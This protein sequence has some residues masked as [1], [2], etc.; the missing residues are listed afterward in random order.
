MKPSKTNNAQNRLFDIRLSDQLNPQNPLY[1]LSEEIDWGYFENEFNPLFKGKNGHPPKPIRLMIG[2]MMLQQIYNESDELVVE[3]WIENPYWQFF[4]GFDYLQWKKPINPT[5]LVYWRKRLGKDGLE[6]ILKATV[7]TALKTKTIKS[8][9]LKKTTSDT[10][11]MPKNITYPTDS[12]LYATGCKILVREA[13]KLK[14]PLRQSFARL[15]KKS[16]IMSGRYAHARQMKRAIREKKRLKTYLGR[17]YRDIQR[18]IKN[19]KKYENSFEEI[20]P[21]IDRLLK[22]KKLDK[23][24]LYSLFEPHTECISKGKAH[25]KYEFG[26]K[27]SLLTTH[28]EGLLLY[29]EAVHGN[30][31]DGHVLKQAVEKA[32][33]ISGRPIESIFVDKGYRGHSVEGKE[34]LISGQKKGIT[35]SLK[36]AMKRRQAIE[37]HIGH[38]K[39]EG[40]MSRNYLKGILGDENNAILCGIGHNLK[41]ILRKLRVFFAQI[42][43]WIKK[44]LNFENN[45]IIFYLKKI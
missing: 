26:C 23:N 32:E 30:P 42:F 38:M 12:K 17:I 11:V 10:T 14:I 9:S 1:R 43:Y 18:K 39:K 40:K 44:S 8:K 27:V 6:K 19:N 24:K 16:L 21:L 41:M 28:K 20:F 13:K 45:N 37:P 22:Q 2:I 25:K 33:Q 4:C 34:V 29:S 36:K 15:A 5:S 3:K 35:R 31:Y 7:K